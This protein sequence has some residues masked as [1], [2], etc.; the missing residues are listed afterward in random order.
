MEWKKIRS[1]P[2]DER[3]VLLMDRHGDMAVA[4]WSTVLKSWQICVGRWVFGPDRWKPTHWMPLPKPPKV[5]ANE[6]A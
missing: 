1:V 6:K 3:P 4:W 2:K 5:G